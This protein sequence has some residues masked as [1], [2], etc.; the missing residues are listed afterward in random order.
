MNK[1]T[2]VIFVVLLAVSTTSFAD[3]YPPENASVLYYKAFMLYKPDDA[4]ESMLA[5]FTNGKIVSNEK[6]KEFL[7]SGQNRRIINTITDASQIP[8]CDWGLNYSEG[9]EMENPSLSS[10]RNLSR[11]ILAD[12]KIHAENGDYKTAFSRCITAKKM[13]IHTGDELLISYLV[14]VAINA[15]ANKSIQ[16]ILNGNIDIQTLKWL[17]SEL[18]DIQKIKLVAKDAL[19]NDFRIASNTKRGKLKDVP[20][21]S[22]TED[23]NL[24][25]KL[26]EVINNQ[27]LFEENLKYWEQYM[28][29]VA[30]AFDLPYLEA[31]S[32]MKEIESAIP[33]QPKK[34]AKAVITAI[35]A[36]PAVKI[37]TISIRDQ[38]NENAL[39]TAV[40]IYI[41]NA[42]NTKL[43]DSLTESSPKDMFSGRDFE[44]AKTKEGFILRCRQKDLDK[45]K[46]QEYEFKLKR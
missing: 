21:E 25:K 16:D 7:N 13:A 4:I 38:S 31:V 46:I 11:L 5:D 45:D 9:F 6:I 20:V 35:F 22:V 37:F 24:Q 33:Q 44:Y 29:S 23:P 2:I 36:P 39:R 14:S 40:D 3:K 42:Q 15:L 27:S 28:L 1:K 43:P 8:N 32:K 41:R 30:D 10:L 17:K 26:N 12:A 19:I 34:N 18:E